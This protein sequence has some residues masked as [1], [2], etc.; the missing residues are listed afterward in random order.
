[1]VVEKTM[2]HFQNGKLCGFKNIIKPENENIYNI[3]RKE[4]FRILC[5]AQSHFDFKNY[6]TVSIL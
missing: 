5:L 6:M 1:M 2:G 4:K 3:L